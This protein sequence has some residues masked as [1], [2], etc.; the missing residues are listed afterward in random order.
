MLN[1]GFLRFGGGGDTS[2][3]TLGLILLLLFAFFIFVVPRRHVLAPLLVGILCLP[4]TAQFVAF[5]LHFTSTRILVACGLLK[6]LIGTRK[7]K[8]QINS[9]DLFIVACVL[10]GAIAF[11]LLWMNTGAFVNRIGVVYDSCGMYLLMRALVEDKESIL[12]AI[13]ILCAVSFVFGI[14]MLLEHFG[15]TNFFSSLT[16]TAYAPEFRAGYVRAQ[17]PFGHEILAGCLGA[18][19]LP[20]IAGTYWMK[21]SRLF[22]LIGMVGAVLMAYSSSS[23][24]ALLSVC[25]GIA[26]LMAW[27]LRRF[28]R[29]F[30]WLVVLMLCTLH[31]VMKAPVWGLIGRISLTD[32]NSSYHRFELVNQ[33][34]LHFSDW[35]LIGI[36][37]TYQWGYNLWDTADTYVETA[38]TGG[39]LS[40]ILLIGILV[41]AY[42]N[43]GKTRKATTEPEK[44]KFAW[45]LAAALTAHV[46]AFFGITYYDQTL[47]GWYLLLAMISATVWS[48]DEVVEKSET[49]TLAPA[50]RANPF[51]ERSPQRKLVKVSDV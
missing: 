33:T 4:M 23:S 31:L 13:R 32:G 12:K 29:P 38:T 40:F 14:F 5:N 9:L 44:A 41:T 49:M 36:K 18:T 11:T 35:W 22:A 10:S 47:I 45:I 26:A 50:A 37:T 19:V 1:Q 46:T 16:R 3:T 42:K 27:P 43:L 24:T 15:R 48:S 30:R 8:L 7:H 34:I 20:L 6:L 25:A 21:Q 17:G 39:L 28:M 2:L 51:L